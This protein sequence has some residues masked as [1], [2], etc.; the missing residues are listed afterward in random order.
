MSK[1]AAA[2]LL[3]A[4]TGAAYALVSSLVQCSEVLLAWLSP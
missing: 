4:I 3:V 2:C 1:L